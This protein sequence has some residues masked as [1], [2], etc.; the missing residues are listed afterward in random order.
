MS[1]GTPLKTAPLKEAL[2][3]DDPGGSVVKNLQSHAG[4]AGSIPSLGTKIP[5]CGASKPN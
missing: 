4:V 3:T 2:S 5:C 1:T